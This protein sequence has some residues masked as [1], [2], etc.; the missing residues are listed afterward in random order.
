MTKSTKKQDDEYYEIGSIV[1]PHLQ[2]HFEQMGKEL[3]S[4]T[5]RHL[6]DHFAQI[7]EQTRE[8]IRAELR[9]KMIDELRAEIRDE[10]RAEIRAKTPDEIIH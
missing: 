6:T 2:H 9:A 4:S 1:L 7:R 3:F 5:Y 10:L 8:Q